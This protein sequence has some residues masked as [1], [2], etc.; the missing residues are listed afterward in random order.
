[1][2]YIND[3]Q[4]I[5]QV[6]PLKKTILICPK[7]CQNHGS[8]PTSLGHLPV[9]RQVTWNILEHTCCL[10]VVS[11]QCPKGNLNARCLTGGGPS[12]ACHWT[13]QYFHQLSKIKILE[14]SWLISTIKKKNDVS[15]EARTT[16]HFSKP[17]H[18]RT[19]RPSVRFMSS[20]S[21]KICT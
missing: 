10:S 3:I 17:G 18:H 6:I 9:E 7:V 15:L 11:W 4:Q 21:P 13:Q 19:V 20:V 5:N 1:M 12:Y 14:I 8:F 2:Y 16:E